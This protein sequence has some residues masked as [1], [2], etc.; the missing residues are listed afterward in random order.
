MVPMDPGPL[1]SHL[2]SYGDD[3]SMP[4]P[5][6]TRKLLT[7]LVLHTERYPAD[8]ARIHASSITFTHCP[9]PGTPSARTLPDPIVAAVAEAITTT[10]EAET[11]SLVNGGA[12]SGPPSTPTSIA[13]PTN[14]TNGSTTL[15][16]SS[17]LDSV[18]KTCGC[19]TIASSATNGNG[20]IAPS[21]SN[22]TTILGGS[23]GGILPTGS[24]A[25]WHDGWRGVIFTDDDRPCVA[26][27]LVQPPKPLD[28]KDVYSSDQLIIG[29]KDGDTEK[30]SDYRTSVLSSFFMDDDHR[31]ETE[32]IRRYDLSVQQPTPGGIAASAAKPF[33]TETS[34]ASNNINTPTVSETKS[35]CTSSTAT[36]TTS[37]PLMPPPTS[38]ADAKH[39]SGS[40]GITPKR[41][42]R[43]CPV[44]CWLVSNLSSSHSSV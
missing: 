13:T 11:S 17:S 15:S 18:S 28:E 43:L 44:R 39:S 24:A 19:S 37:L 30:P 42:L 6:L 27:K 26:Y 10:T 22:K 7:L 36:P 5:L 14:A 40:H 12:L 25:T 21:S 9:A 38:L 31:R 35:T 16:S 8:I 2:L 20:L 23:T 1:L 33:V 32:R 4:L 34:T 41:D 29:L 3:A